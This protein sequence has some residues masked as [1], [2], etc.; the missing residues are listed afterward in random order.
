MGMYFTIQAH[1]DPK[2]YAV[3]GLKINYMTLVKYLVKEHALRFNGN[4]VKA[5]NYKEIGK[6]NMTQ[7]LPAW[8]QRHLLPCNQTS[9]KEL[10]DLCGPEQNAILQNKK[11]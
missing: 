6:K 11:G 2:D 9:K 7:Y 5:I 8:Y 4:H 3:H 10:S 1:K